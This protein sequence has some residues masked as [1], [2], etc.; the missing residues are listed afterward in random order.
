MTKWLIENGLFDDDFY[1]NL[2]KSLSD[3]SIEY[4]SID[5]YCDF[6]S[7][8]KMS[9][10]IESNPDTFFV[11]YGCIN[12]CKNIQRIFNE[13]KHWNN[14]LFL[15]MNNLSFER[16][17]SYWIDYCLN[18]DYFIVTYERFCNNYDILF[19]VFGIDNSIFARPISNDKSFTGRL[20]HKDSFEHDSLYMGYSCR[21]DLPNDLL[22]A[23]S[24]PKNVIKEW[25]FAIYNN[26]I[27]S[28]SLYNV[29]GLN[30]EE[31]G[32]HDEDVVNLV[33][34]VLM[35]SW[36]PDDVY[37]LDVGKLEDGSC[38]VIEI[39]SLNCAGWYKMDI[40]NIVN[41]IENFRIN[42]ENKDNY[43]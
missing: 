2:F 6:A 7:M 43:K 13:L 26:L 5:N 18:H 17:S 32:C 29:N 38:K 40:S 14:G 12:F 21:V 10:V 41:M 16:Y 20:F 8:D 35:D 1:K 24:S 25:R 36:R 9:K 34:K 39:G 22:I 33:K 11:P 30:E 27:V 37:I 23:V 3:R 19:D 31:C 15:R 42:T 4:L 28:S